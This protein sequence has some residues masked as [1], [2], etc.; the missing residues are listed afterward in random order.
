MFDFEVFEKI[1]DNGTYTIKLFV[2]K[3]R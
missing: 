2:R 1:D 3:I